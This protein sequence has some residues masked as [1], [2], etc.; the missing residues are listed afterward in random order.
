MIQPIFYNQN[1][2]PDVAVAIVEIDTN[3]RIAK[4]EIQSKFARLAAN[5]AANESLEIIKTNL[6]KPLAKNSNL[7]LSL[8]HSK[9]WGA[10][11]VS[12]QHLLGIDIE[13]LEERIERIAHKFLQPQELE[14]ITHNRIETLTLYWSAKESLYKLYSK[15]QLDFANQLLIKP[16]E[17]NAEGE[18]IASIKIDT[19][20]EIKNIKL[21]Y[22]FF[23]THVLTVASILPQEM[24]N[25]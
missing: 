19:I 7:H 24:P 23:N 20:T 5:I 18:L 14:N 17:I 11:A 15:K 22:K 21:K 9:Y 13:T 8:S 1:L 4:A 6:G 12:K 2:L 16:F 3:E 10:A 25:F